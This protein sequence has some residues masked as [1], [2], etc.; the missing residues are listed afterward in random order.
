MQFKDRVVIV[1]AAASGI[2]RAI[3]GRFATE[4]AHLAICDVNADTLETTAAELSA[5]SP[6][7]MHKVVDVSDFEA[8]QR[9]VAETVDTLAGWTLS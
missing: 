8:V 6:G 7:V 3:A 2:G 5:I 4:G 1:S 9:F